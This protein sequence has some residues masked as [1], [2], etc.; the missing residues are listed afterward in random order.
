MLFL[1][2]LE[3]TVE[4]LEKVDPDFIRYKNSGMVYLMAILNRKL[5]RD[6]AIPTEF[7]NVL[8]PE[9]PIHW[10]ARHEFILSRD[11]LAFINL[12][13]EACVSGYVVRLKIIGNWVFGIE[14]T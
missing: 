7:D 1:F 2:H 13:R 9:I 3:H 14:L 4:Y 10:S 11:I 12:L 8:P 5:N 6:Y